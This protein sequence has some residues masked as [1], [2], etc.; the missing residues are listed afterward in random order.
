MKVL[1]VMLAICA[2][3]LGAPA[4][5]Q[6]D[7]NDQRTVVANVQGMVCDF[8]ARGL[9]KVFGRRP[10]VAKIGVSLEQGK[11]WIHLQPGADISDAEITELILGNGINVE[12]IERGAG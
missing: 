12:S 11:V 7:E 2:V 9:E 5:G 1:I 4:F 8:C 3:T 10:E 6:D